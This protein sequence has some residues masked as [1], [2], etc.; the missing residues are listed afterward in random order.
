[1]TYFNAKQ[2]AQ[3]LKPI[4]PNRVG[5]DGKGFSHVEAYEIRAHLNRVV[6]FARWSADLTDLALI[7]ATDNQ[8][9]HTVCYRATVRL[10]V[11][12]PDGTQLATYTEAATGE[13]KNQPHLGDA[14]DL[15]M[16]T[17]ESQAFKRCAVNLGDNF[18]LSLY[19]KGSLSPL[20]RAT[21]VDAAGDAAPTEQ[22]EEQAPVDAH[23]T[24]PLP[25][26]SEQA[27]DKRETNAPKAAPQPRQADVRKP[28]VDAIRQEALN[29]PADADG[30]WWSRLQL[31]AT[32]G[33][34]LNAK[35]TDADGNELTVAALIQGEMKK[36]RAA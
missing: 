4:N 17:A 3:L 30:M 10:T 21:L 13:A 31:K 11:C 5:R 29:P 20:V 25:A 35:T 19:A 6:G 15:A 22:K 8:G 18:G 12:A 24:E 32:Q 23:L 33:K 9:K 36:K 16:K 2:H 1:M 27:E 28:V 34:V 26:E 7:F 14:H